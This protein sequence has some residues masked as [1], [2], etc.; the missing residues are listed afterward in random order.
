MKQKVSSA[1]AAA[2]AL[3]TPEFLKREFLYEYF[4]FDATV[5]VSLTKEGRREVFDRYARLFTVTETEWLDA[6]F[7][8]AEHD[9]ARSAVTGEDM[10]RLLRCAELYDGIK[11]HLSAILSFK[12]QAV[13]KRDPIFE[14]DSPFEITYTLYSLEKAGAEGHIAASC[15]LAFLSLEGFLS[16]TEK[17]ESEAKLWRAF[18]WNSPMAC[19]LAITHFPERKSECAERLRTMLSHRGEKE[20]YDYLK[21]IYELPCARTSAV[22]EALEEAF[23]R[24]VLDRASLTASTL[25]ILDSTVLTEDSKRELILTEPKQ[26]PR[27]LPLGITGKSLPLTA[28]KLPRGVFAREKEE[29]LIENNLLYRLS[30]RKRPLLLIAKDDVLLREYKERIRAAYA[31]R[32]YGSIDLSGHGGIHLEDAVLR[33][34]D[35]IGE[36]APL[37][38]FEKCEAL[39]ENEV[40]SLATL[41]KSDTAKR[42]VTAS[43]YTLDLSGVLTVMLAHEKPNQKLV[44]ISDVVIL[45][46]VKEAEAEAAIEKI[47][48]DSARFFSIRSVE[49]SDG[50]RKILLK[51]TA[52]AAERMIEHA[53]LAHCSGTDHFVITEKMLEDTEKANETKIGIWGGF[54]NV[55]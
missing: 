51:Q 17:E 5:G 49:L 29:S 53:L 36:N 25:S 28:K 1:L 2:S 42:Y 13:L 21:E 48:S 15:L 8:A 23:E 4:F 55:K 27:T 41:L 44:M 39:G 19:L 38:F 11:E 6:C 24:K 3:P 7:A 16:E 45:E 33:T 35:G 46:N 30:E 22:A 54:G 20:V 26:Y 50:A 9:L 32:G 37:I 52:S 34:L 47:L 18:R 40:P 31:E 12:L 14:K 10:N 43:G